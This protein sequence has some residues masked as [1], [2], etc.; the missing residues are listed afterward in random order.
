MTHLDI[1]ESLGVF[2]LDA[3]DDDDERRTIEAHLA[4]CD[5]CSEEVA[6][7][8]EV[9]SKLA[10][11]ERWAPPGLWDGI[12]TQLVEPET[13]DAAGLAEVVP[14]R[15]P[16]LRMASIAAAMVLVGSA[17]VVQ[18]AR[19]DRASDDLRAAQALAAAAEVRAA[20]P[21]LAQVASS[22]V[23]DP[24]AQ[25]VSLDASDSTAKAII[26]LMPDG[27]GYVTQHTLEPLPADRTY[28]LWAIVDGR[29]IS[30]GVLGPNPGTVPF[31]IDVAGFEGFAITEEVAGGV[32]SS[33]ND[34]VV[35]F[36]SA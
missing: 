20:R 29:V 19:L 7:H 32:V 17:A 8:R 18:T 23:A 2:A 13:A 11:T 15:R 30:A 34:P 10:A 36:L 21:A 26:V 6:E 16:W 35:A 24:G 1:Q 28:Q 22:A 33:V 14:L 5:E 12:A 9:V 31:H 25:L 4:V 3:I 27:T